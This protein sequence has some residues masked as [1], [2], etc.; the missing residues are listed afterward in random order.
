MKKYIILLDIIFYAAIPLI[1][2]NA[3]R[4]YLGDYNTILAS[5]IP[6]I[7]Y[8]AF[9]FY[10]VKKINFTGIFI[11]ASLI[12][13]TASDFLAGSALQLLWNNVFYSIA[14][15]LFFLLTIFSNK[16]AALLLSLDLAEMQG[17]DRASMNDLFWQKKVLNVFKLITMLFA[18]RELVLSFVMLLLIK[19]YGVEAFDHGIIYKQAITWSFTIV[20]I[21]GFI[22]ISKLINQDPERI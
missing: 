9:R 20:C 15:A 5:S 1:V 3:G 19:K 2:W 21:G 8:S 6:G 14:V 4:G 10:E 18:A 13:G 11:L 17:N 22:Y 16:P 12:I 7:L